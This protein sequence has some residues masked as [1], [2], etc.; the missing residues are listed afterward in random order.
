MVTPKINTMK[1]F[2]AAVAVYEYFGILFFGGVCMHMADALISPLVGGVMWTA[3]AGSIAYSTAKIKNELGEKKVPV[4]AVTGAF[5]FAAQMINFTIPATGSSGHI[6]GGILLAGLLGPF[7][8]LLT[9]AAVLMIQALFFA[10]GGLL[11]LGCNIFN[12]GVIPC[13]LVY[14]LLFKPIVQRGFSVSR[15]GGAALLSVMVGLELGAFGVVV[16]TLFSGITALPFSTF[17]LLM[18]PIHLA[19]GVVE[20]I[21]TALVLNFVYKMRPEILESSEQRIPLAKTVPVKKIVLLLGLITLCVGGILSIF[22]SA[23]PDGLEW[24]MEKTAG[25]AELETEGPVFRQA[26]AIQEATAFM[27]DYNFPGAEEDG[28]AAGTVVAGIVGAA[29]TC[30]LAGAAGFIIYR[31]KLRHS[32]NA[33]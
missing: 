28:S 24:A 27:P 15:L 4:M 9:I 5:V 7:P 32:E 22:A 21:V 6:G 19:I 10:D 29:L 16:E 8:A 25:T 3:A 17:V 2:Y 18:L 30:L 33:A 11:A 14:P 23:Y 12:M 26:E 20:G 1:V 31:I 13:L